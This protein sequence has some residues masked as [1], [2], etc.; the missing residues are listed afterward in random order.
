MSRSNI[1]I[2]KYCFRFALV[3]ELDI[4]RRKLH[5]KLL[6]DID[7]MIIFRLLPFHVFDLITI[8]CGLLLFSP[9]CYY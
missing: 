2:G 3:L 8:Y 9:E 6:S 7:L 1:G 4:D 5:L